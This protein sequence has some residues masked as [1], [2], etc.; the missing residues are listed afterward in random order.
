MGEVWFSKAAS[1]VEKLGRA[2][3]LAQHI[4]V[5]KRI[6]TQGA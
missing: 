6:I 5:D 1:A 2:G 4:F 3:G